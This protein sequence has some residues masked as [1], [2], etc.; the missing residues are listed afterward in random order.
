[1]ALLAGEAI[2]KMLQ[3]EKKISSKIN[4]DVLR[5]LS[6]DNPADMLSQHSLTGT[7]STSDSCA[8]AASST[9]TV[10]GRIPDVTQP[11]YLPEVV[12]ES[13]LPITTRR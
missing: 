13:H 6:S 1:M 12:D 5:N 11:Q 4:Y 8:T 3:H 10:D 7:T 2:E 9:T